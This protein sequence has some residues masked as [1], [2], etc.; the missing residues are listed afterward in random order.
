MVIRG[1]RDTLCASELQVSRQ[2][3]GTKKTCSIGQ[4]SASE[5]PAVRE[6][7]R[8]HDKVVVVGGRGVKG[9]GRDRE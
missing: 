7:S 9:R 5:N 2:G 4:L 1:V 3:G 6:N 8:S